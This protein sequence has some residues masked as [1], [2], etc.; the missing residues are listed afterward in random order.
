[1]VPFEHLV[2]SRHASKDA[3]Y[4]QLMQPLS[5]LSASP[6][7]RDRELICGKIYVEQAV[8]V[9]KMRG[10]GEPANFNDGVPGASQ[11][12][13]S[14]PAMKETPRGAPRE[15]RNNP[16]APVRW[17]PNPAE[18]QRALTGVMTPPPPFTQY[19]APH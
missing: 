18:R 16:D 13:G 14:T 4:S 1:M 7:V 3:I 17:Q 2:D 5:S 9:A 6:L 10:P 19:I 8:P 15:G 12:V 11:T